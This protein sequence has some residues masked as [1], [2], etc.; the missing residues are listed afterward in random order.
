MH[1]TAISPAATQRAIDR[2]GQLRAFS[3]LR[4]EQ[5]APLVVDMQ[6]GF[7]APDAV[8]EVPAAREIVSNINRI[9]AALR[10]AGGS[11]VYI[12]NTFD[13][14][15]VR[16]WSIYFE[17]FRTPARRERMIAAF[18]PGA[19]GHAL[20]AALEVRPQDLCVRKRRFSPFVAGS[21]ELH[22]T[23]PTQHRYA[24]HHRYIVASLLR[25]DR[26]RCDDAELQGILY[27]R[28]QC[29]VHGCRGQCRA[30]S[31]GTEVL[32]RRKRGDGVR[33]D[34]AGVRAPLRDVTPA[35]S[36]VCHR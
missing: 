9:G 30:H 27:Q 15:A 6:N 16:T 8:A 33:P 7:V 17:H 34:R 18:T 4:P 22:A 14:E 1:Q 26:T 2:R 28:W 31:D 36:A 3:C 32:R 12:Q 29:D 23:A 20:W 13:A 25:I 10:S 24:H 21:S 19:Q 35:G 11:V 5:T